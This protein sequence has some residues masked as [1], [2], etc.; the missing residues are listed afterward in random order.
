MTRGRPRPAAA[1]RPR[2]RHRPWPTLRSSDPCRGWRRRTARVLKLSTTTTVVNHQNHPVILLRQGS[3]NNNS[4]LEALPVRVRVGTKTTRPPR[5]LRP[6]A[7]PER[8]KAEAEGNPARHRDSKTETAAAGN[9]AIPT[10][11][12]LPPAPTR[13]SGLRRKRPGAVALCKERQK[14]LYIHLHPTKLWF[15]LNM[16]DKTN[17][18]ELEE[19]GRAS[20]FD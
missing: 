19:N 3:S 9:R 1:S 12:S 8:V 16:Y 14:Q 17:W 4:R 13:S 11:K 18:S 20:N 6:S 15:D 10:W 5:P 2:L 7:E